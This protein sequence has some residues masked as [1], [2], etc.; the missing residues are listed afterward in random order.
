MSAEIVGKLWAVGALPQTPLVQFLF[1]I[2][3]NENDS[4]DKTI[5]KVKR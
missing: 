3:Q 4:E 1:S 2:N 5:T